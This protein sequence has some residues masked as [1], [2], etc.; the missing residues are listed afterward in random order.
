MSR[1]HSV[2]RILKCQNYNE[3]KK[4]LYP[5]SKS[6]NTTYFGINMNKFDFK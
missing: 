2:T 4:Y 1:P 5:I 6:F 3:L